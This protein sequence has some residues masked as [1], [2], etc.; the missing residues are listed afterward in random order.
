MIAGARPHLAVMRKRHSV[1]DIDSGLLLGSIIED[2]I[3]TTFLALSGANHPPLHLAL[4]NN[5]EIKAKIHKEMEAEVRKFY[6]CASSDECIR[7]LEPIGTGPDK[8]HL[9][10]VPWLI[11]I[12]A[13]R[14]GQFDDGIRYKK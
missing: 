2:C 10:D 1:W 6:S 8:P 14:C 11:V 4:I 3:Q 13:E 9:V 12:F 7:A 5:L